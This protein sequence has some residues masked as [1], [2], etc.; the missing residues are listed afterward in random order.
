MSG[1]EHADDLQLH[2]IHT[3]AVLRVQS[4]GGLLSAAGCTASC[5]CI[6]GF[7]QM[8]VESCFCIYLATI[9]T[10]SGTGGVQVGRMQGAIYAW[11]DGIHM[12]LECNDLL[13]EQAAVNWT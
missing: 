8:E 11:L 13:S 4:G 1:Q 2:Q 7:V 9:W 5:I 10:T 6:D 3:L 12:H